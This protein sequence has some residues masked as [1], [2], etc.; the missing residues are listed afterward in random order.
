MFDFFFWGNSRL[1][2]IVDLQSNHS[3]GQFEFRK[4]QALRLINWHSLIIHHTING[5]PQIKILFFV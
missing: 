1:L 4:I 2:S 5:I 3:A